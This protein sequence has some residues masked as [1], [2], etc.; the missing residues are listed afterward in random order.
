MSENQNNSFQVTAFNVD[1]T[2]TSIVENGN[3]FVEMHP[4]IYY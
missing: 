3:V 2:A 4:E 1:E